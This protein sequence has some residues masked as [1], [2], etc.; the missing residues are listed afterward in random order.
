MTNNYNKIVIVGSG[1]AGLA[2]ANQIIKNNNS[3]T[4][5]TIIEKDNSIGGC[6]KVHRKS[7]NGENYFCEHGPR[8]YLN[9]YVNFIYL[10]KEM[11]LNFND[12]FIKY[13]YNFFNISNRLI[14]TDKI[15]SLSEL[16]AIVRD[17][18]FT[19]FSNTYGINIS[20]F[21]YMKLNNF[22][23][24]TI[25]YIDGFCRS[26]DGGDSS[27]ISLNQFMNLS[28]QCL[29]YSIYLPRLPNDEGLFK[30]WKNYLTKNKV[31]F[32][33]NNG[34]S[35]IITDDEKKIVKSV[36]LN[37]GREIYADLFILAIPPENILSIIPN[38]FGNLIT[39]DFVNKTKYNDYISIT[40]HWDYDIGI[41][42]DI[43]GLNTKTEWG[44]LVMIMSD[45]MK[46]K[47]SSS[48][49]VIS[50]AIILTDTKDS[51]LNKTANECSEKELIDAV[52]KQLLS[53]FKNI[54][55]PTLYFIN[56]YYDKNLKKWV[57]NEKAFIKVPNVNY[58][59]F[60]S[61][62]YKNL[63][64]L[65]THNGKH[66]NSFTS[67][68]SAISNSIKLNNIIFNKKNRIKRCFDF[69]DFIIVFL[70]IIIVLLIIVY[71]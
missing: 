16:F 10:L 66:K 49:S 48:K 18:L 34:V 20:M 58:I 51:Y 55:K 32:I 69:R 68:E 40:L 44:L 60:K 9:N 37:D 64:N 50:C 24:K 56:N 23:N 3:N 36:I 12:I 4:H 62:N 26:F 52:Y 38:S 25:H 15:F 27:R 65:G 57:S 35:K 33:T 6:H 11:K 29:F 53:V 45:Y 17:F 43:F 28:I 13:K 8:I 59:D 7:Y 42:K 46:F 67:V 19:I 61:P 14:F 5:I 1:V 63:Y 41:D 71:K 47:E 70:A 30:Y 39:N 54:P 2:F 31:N 22:S 21:D